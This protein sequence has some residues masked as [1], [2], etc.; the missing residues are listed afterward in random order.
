METYDQE[1]FIE[2]R[3]KKI[4]QIKSDAKDL[5]SLAT[6]INGKVHQQD[7]KLDDLNKELEYNVDELH[8]ANKDLE[9]AAKVSGK[10]NKCL[11]MMLLFLALLVGGGVIS[12]LVL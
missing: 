5:N 10:S 8:K 7:E 6:T 2:K 9:T 4:K 12:F 3:A 1:A 11:L